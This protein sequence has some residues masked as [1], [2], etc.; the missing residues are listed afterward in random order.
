MN[1]A[2]TSQ[3]EGF[4]EGQHFGESALLG[5]EVAGEIVAVGSAVTDLDFMLEIAVR[6][7][8][9]PPNG[10]HHTAA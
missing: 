5:L 2:D 7:S 8:R 9:A 3:R 4:Y 6:V 1:R 10:G